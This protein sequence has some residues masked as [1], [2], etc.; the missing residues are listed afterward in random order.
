MKLSYLVPAA[1]SILTVASAASADPAPAAAEKKIN[2]GAD[3]HFGLPIGNLANGTGPQI[4]AVLRGGYMVMPELEVTLRTGYVF[5]LSKD[6]GFGVDASISYIPIMVGGRYFVMSPGAGLYG[7]LE[8]GPNILML[9]AG[10][11]TATYGPVTVAVPSSSTTD[12]KFGGQLGIGYVI[13]KELPLD[14]KAQF[15]M[16]DIGDAG[17]SMTVGLNVG[18]TF[19]SF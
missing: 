13:S 10:G 14:I 3:L 4:G 8:L 16:L 5:G 15:Q 17:N 19:A 12:V 11:G 18:Y 7:G 9:K 6:V 2:L 1:L